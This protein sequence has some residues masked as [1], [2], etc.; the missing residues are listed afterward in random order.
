MANKLIFIHGV[1]GAGKS[2]FLGYLAYALRKRP[3]IEY[4]HEL[5]KPYAQAGMVP[6][7]ELP[8]AMLNFARLS[9]S[10]AKSHVISEDPPEKALLYC[11]DPV[12]TQ[13]VT[14][15]NAKLKA[16]VHRL[17][18]LLTPPDRSRYVSHGRY[19]T[20]E[21]AIALQT[22]LMSLVMPDM[23]VLNPYTDTVLATIT[24]FLDC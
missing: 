9:K 3:D 24:E 7:Y 19:Q 2:T 13:Y 8:L 17:D 23:L 11:K 10:L 22:E 5:I 4:M 15:E 21:Q 6:D 18:I 20:Y 16:Y 1:P 12:V 14:N